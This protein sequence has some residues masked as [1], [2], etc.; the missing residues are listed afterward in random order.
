MEE[1][2]KPV[3]PAN[4]LSAQTK[5]F[6]NPTGNFVIGGPVGDCGLT[7]RKLLSTPT[8]V[9]QGM[10]AEH[11]LARTLKSRPKRRLRWSLRG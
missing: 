4:W 2:I 7:G 6:I 5:Y 10:A 3:L 1:I 9:W 11:S 8:A